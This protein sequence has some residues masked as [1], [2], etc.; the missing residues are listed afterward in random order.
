MSDFE[1]NKGKLIPVNV[2]TEH[3]SED[4]Y[5][6]YFENGFV[7]V[8]GEVYEVEWEVEAETDSYNFCEVKENEDGTIDFHTMHYNGGGSF[9]EIVESSLKK[10]EKI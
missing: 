4:D 8:D 10:E 6:T 9:V 2:D 1:R 5:N 3:F 7:V